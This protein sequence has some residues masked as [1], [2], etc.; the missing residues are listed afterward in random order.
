MPQP[1]DRRERGGA[2]N[3]QGLGQRVAP[4]GVSGVNASAIGTPGGQ[5]PQG[6]E[7][8]RNQARIVRTGAELYE[9][10]AGLAKGVSNGVEQFD[11]WSRKVAE[12]EYN[13]FESRMIEY[14]RTVNN[15]P[16][17]MADWIKN[18]G[19]EPHRTTANKYLKTLALAEGKEYEALQDDKYAEIRKRASVLDLAEQADMLRKELT[20]L[21]PD[22]SAAAKVKRDLD[23]ANGKLALL[24]QQGRVFHAGENMTSVITDVGT[25]LQQIPGWMPEYF[26]G[27]G[28]TIAAGIAYYGV[29]SDKLQILPD[30]TIR[31]QTGSG[32]QART[33]E[34]SMLGDV[35]DIAYAIQEDMGRAGGN[36]DD[37]S[38]I[39]PERAMM[40]KE[41]IQRGKWPASMKRRE[42]AGRVKPADP[43][44][45]LP[46]VYSQSGDA[47]IRAAI[48]AEAAS[49]TALDPDQRQKRAEGLLTELVD[50][51][52]FSD[53]DIDTKILAY[54]QLLTATDPTVNPQWWAGFGYEDMGT[55]DSVAPNALNKLRTKAREQLTDLRMG[56]VAEVDAQLTAVTE[57]TTSLTDFDSASVAAMQTSMVA[58]DPVYGGFSVTLM[59]RD[60]ATGEIVGGVSFRSQ[61]AARQYMFDNP[62]TVSSGM[63]H[64]IND[65]LNK[66]QQ[67]GPRTFVG[68]S[69]AKPPLAVVENAAIA[70]ATRDS[71]MNVNTVLADVASD[72]RDLDVGNEKVIQA[73]EFLISRLPDNPTKDDIAPVMGILLSGKLD[74]GATEGI[75]NLI[76]GEAQDKFK[77]VYGLT[78]DHSRRIREFRG[79]A[80]AMRADAQAH[81]DMGVTGQGIQDQLEAADRVEVIQALAANPDNQDLLY[82]LTGTKENNDRDLWYAVTAP[83]IV[84][85]LEAQKLPPPTDQTLANMRALRFIPQGRELARQAANGLV[86]AL[87]SGEITLTP[88]GSIAFMEGTDGTQISGL[89][90]VMFKTLAPKWAKE[91]DKEDPDNA[92]LDQVLADPD[93][94]YHQQARDWVQ[95]S[96]TWVMGNANIARLM[97]EQSN[98][99][100]AALSQEQRRNANV[101]PGED[102]N[103]TEDMMLKIFEDAAKATLLPVMGV[104]V[105]ISQADSVSVAGGDYD[106]DIQTQTVMAGTAALV[107][108]RQSGAEEGQTVGGIPDVAT[109]YREAGAEMPE[110]QA[111]IDMLVALM[112]GGPEAAIEALNRHE[113]GQPNL[114]LKRF[115][116]ST[117][118]FVRPQPGVAANREDGDLNNSHYSVHW[119]RLDNETWNS[120][121]ARRQTDFTRIR[122]GSRTDEDGNARQRWYIGEAA[123]YAEANR[124]KAAKAR[125]AEDA[126][127]IAEAE[128]RGESSISANIAASM[129]RERQ[130][131]KDRVRNMNDQGIYTFQQ[132]YQNFLKWYHSD[133]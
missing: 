74:G 17:K 84:A 110:G 71:L 95:R 21:P 127:L 107:D 59:E 56:K 37:P 16:R 15:D 67:L 101:T 76:T 54:E 26:E 131:R 78:Q 83:R 11:K 8:N 63:V 65:R 94:P 89:E 68:P 99:F 47:Q 55:E 9:A 111:G 126:R 91:M 85:A 20:R 12:K 122:G 10:L 69:G 60:P 28:E 80:D 35:Q 14:G 128:A 43:R 41:A 109:M 123:M 3:R 112:E 39:D 88:Q 50:S 72:R 104:R 106:V 75:R 62:A 121:T 30:G 1:D 103:L 19:Y 58:A 5:G 97:G 100:A 46:F 86:N 44:A 114:V 34:G 6:I 73:A 81:I 13:D 124:D 40:V 38:S 24:A 87:A 108:A 70:V 117:K 92:R 42:S 118:E 61:D 119:T 113:F 51:I 66:P 49:S 53:Q 27:H 129:R 29:D 90:A 57:N 116:E 52:V 64:I 33:I 22:G 45:V 18:S 36:V 133:D 4:E 2:I 115:I 130:W 77:S 82:A 120:L 105:R 32:K 23:E 96:T 31:Y 7:I 25:A 132:H 98:I 79:N 102:K 48:T 125:A 93:N